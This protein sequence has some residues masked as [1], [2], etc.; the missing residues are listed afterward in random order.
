MQG[1]LCF[2]WTTPG[3]YGQQQQAPY[4]APITPSAP[5]LKKQYQEEPKEVYDTSRIVTSRSGFSK[6]GHF[7]CF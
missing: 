1:R 5:N 2:A 3:G 4:G 6:W 7:F